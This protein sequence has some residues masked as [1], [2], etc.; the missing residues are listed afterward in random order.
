[1]RFGGR[2]TN[3]VEEW[4]ETHLDECNRNFDETTGDMEAIV[5]EILW[6]SQMVTPR[7]ARICAIGMCMATWS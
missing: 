2:D 3:D 1:M 6:E 4:F 7:H 5:A